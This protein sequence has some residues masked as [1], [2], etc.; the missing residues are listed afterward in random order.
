MC[1]AI[2]RPRRT[3]ITDEILR[4]CASQNRDGGGYAF[5]KEDKVEVRKGFFEIGDFIASYRA[6]ERD[7]PDSNFLIHFRISTG[8]DRSADNT[9]PFSNGKTAIIHN[10]SFFYP[11]QTGPSDTNIL[12]SA[13]LEYATPGKV[14]EQLTKIGELVGYYNKMAFLFSDNTYLIAN[15][16]QGT[17]DNGIWYS[18]SGF[19]PYRS[20]NTPAVIGGPGVCSVP[21]SGASSYGREV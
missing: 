17:W 3:V 19:R 7:N 15:A 1:I 21:T 2:V 9:H 18:H 12:A 5:V 13:I 14:G 8:G 11:G 6:D 20:H 4:H 10:G 16:A